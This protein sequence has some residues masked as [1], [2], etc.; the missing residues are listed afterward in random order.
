MDLVQS[1]AV[2]NE[3]E[4]L[5]LFDG[6]PYQYFHDNERR[7]HKAWDSLC[8]NYAKPEVIHFLLSNCQYWLSEYKFDGFRFDGVTS[9]LYLDHGLNR[10]FTNYELYY[11]NREDEDAIVYLTLANKMI[12]EINPSAVTIAE[13]MS[14][15][16]G[17]ASP[18]NGGGFGF[19]YR[20]AMGV[21]DYWIKIIKELP[22]EQWNMQHLYNELISH[23]ADEK[24]ISYCESHDQALVGDKTI[25]FRLADKDMYYN[26]S[27]TSQSLIIDRAMSLHK[28]IRLI[29]FATA[30]SGYLNFMGNEFGHPEWID[31]PRQGNNWSFKYARRQWN[32]VE[33]HDLKYHFLF[34]FDSA[35]INLLKDT[36]CF[37]VSFPTLLN[38]DINS[39]VLSFKRNNWIFVFN[40]SPANS[41]TDYKIQVESGKYNILLT[42]DDEEFGGQNRIDKSILYFTTFEG[43]ITTL[44]ANYLSLYIPARTGIVLKK[45]PTKSVY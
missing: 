25:I 32:L 1:H 42:T 24:A 26:M 8:F 16:P 29:T 4:G 10:N 44:R 27:A 12:H 38:A 37:D 41:Y 6:T 43:L 19:D 33:N 3:Q 14:G 30:G 45:M 36:D 11:D 18:F 28:M 15:M 34:D 5:G 31:F 23:R 40:F 13:E 39:Q 35:M 21:P 2:K 20:L 9:M 7:N 22:D 17:L